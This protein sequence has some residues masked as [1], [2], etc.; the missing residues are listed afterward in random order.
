MDKA[1]KEESIAHLHN[2]KLIDEYEWLRDKNWPV[3]NSIEIIDYLN[4][5]NKKTENYF[6][7]YTEIE[8]KGT[9][10]LKLE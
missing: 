2:E 9:V 5:E 10:K 8:E 1:I 3:V 4:S 7:K 6:N